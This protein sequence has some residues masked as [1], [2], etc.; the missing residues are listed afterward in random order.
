MINNTERERVVSG[1]EW[2]QTR[3]PPAQLIPAEDTQSVS[4]AP[5]LQLSSRTTVGLSYGRMR[6][7][8]MRDEK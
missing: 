6:G 2:R 3:S 8:L 1:A 7:R 4:T 5:A